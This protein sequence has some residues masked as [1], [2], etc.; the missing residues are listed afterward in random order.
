[1]KSTWKLIGTLICRKTKGQSGMG[2]QKSLST[3]K[4]IQQILILLIN[5]TDILL[6]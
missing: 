2:Q 3:I 1:M 5:V 6:T 4:S